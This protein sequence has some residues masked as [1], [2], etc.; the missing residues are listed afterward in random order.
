MLSWYLC[1]SNDLLTDFKVIR[2]S[3]S[4]HDRPEPPSTVFGFPVL[5]LICVSI[6]IHHQGLTGVKLSATVHKSP[7][8]KMARIQQDGRVNL[9]N[10]ITDKIKQRTHKKLCY[11]W[12]SGIKIRHRAI[13]LIKR[14]I[15]KK[16]MRM[17]RKETLFGWCPL[18]FSPFWVGG[19]LLM[20]LALRLL[21]LRP[22]CNIF[23]PQFCVMRPTT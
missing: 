23:Y 18:P 19:L 1:Q 10:V 22:V 20:I 4:L 9:S 14:E 3:I 5:F 6:F 17:K 12:G 16:I 13:F 21:F 15:N 11:C 8:R 2:T 7:E